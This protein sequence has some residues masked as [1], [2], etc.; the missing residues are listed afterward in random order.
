M[1]TDDILN[2]A[3][4]AQNKAP[5]PDCQVEDE[6]YY[7]NPNF[8]IAKLDCKPGDTV[9]FKVP[10]W[11]NLSWEYRERAVKYVSNMAPDGVKVLFMDKDV[12][13]VIVRCD[14]PI[15]F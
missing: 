12:E 6:D 4:Q 7:R 10:G 1:K 15:Q 2:A 14:D 3:R 9:V 11:A 13:L 5:D 8:I